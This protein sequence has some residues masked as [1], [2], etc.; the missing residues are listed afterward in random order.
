[1]AEKRYYR[2]S[3]VSRITGVEPH[4]LRYWEKEFRQIRPRRIKNQRLYTKKD[5]EIIKEIKRLVHIEGFTISGAKK[6]LEGQES[7][8][9]PLSQIKRDLLELYNFLAEGR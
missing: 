6:R 4:V 5:L 2:I 7:N 9:S 3:E 1:M 8:S